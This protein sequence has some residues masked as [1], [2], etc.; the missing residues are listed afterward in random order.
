[1]KELI[2]F[3]YPLLPHARRH[4][5]AGYEDYNSFRDWLR[6]E[7]TFRCVYCLHR[8]QWYNRGATFHI[9]HL[10]PSALNPEQSC[11]YSNLLYA[12]GTCNNAKQDIL[13][14]PD[15]CRVA[16]HEC[17]RVTAN[18]RVDALNSDGE[19]LEKVLQL[20]RTSHLDFRF[21]WMRTLDSLRVKDPE[22]YLEYMGFPKNLPDLRSKRPPKN[23]RPEGV[24]NCY[25]ALRERGELPAIY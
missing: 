3:E 4:A 24:L 25:F 19:R 17:L 21:R 9:D 14:L 11:E 22:L 10:N 20:N 7:F 13:G 12:C 6:D 5:P 18:G 23:E 16:F 8:E 1:M 15:P 2:G